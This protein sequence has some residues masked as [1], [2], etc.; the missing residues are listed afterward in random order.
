VSDADDGVSGLLDL[1]IW[2]VFDSDVTW[3]VV[4]G[5]SHFPLSCCCADEAIW[6]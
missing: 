4:N 1:R 6:M 3:A 5:R 2:D